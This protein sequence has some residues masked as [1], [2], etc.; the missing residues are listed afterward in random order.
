MEWKILRFFL[1][2]TCSNSPQCSMYGHVD[3]VQGH[4]TPVLWPKPCKPV[5]AKSYK[6]HFLSSR[7]QTV[8]TYTSYQ[9]EAFNTEPLK[10][11]Q[12]EST[13]LLQGQFPAFYILMEVLTALGM[14]FNIFFFST[15]EDYVSK[16]THM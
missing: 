11:I 10:A 4:R 7:G 2:T 16:K 14:K 1:S 8:P 15:V 6:S 5:L 13:P 3:F 9:E 12:Y